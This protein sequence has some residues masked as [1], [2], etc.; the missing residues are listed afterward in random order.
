[1]ADGLF[2]IPTGIRAYQDDQIKLSELATRQKTADAS[3]RLADAQVANFAADNA[4]L[5]A[6]AKDKR[7]AEADARRIEQA[8]GRL[9]QGLPAD[10]SEAPTV[11]PLAGGTKFDALLDRGAAQV[12]YLQSIGR[13]KEANEQLAKLSGA[14]KNLAQARQAAT[15]AKENEWDAATRQHDFTS[16]ILSGVVDQASYDQAR[17]ALSASPLFSAEDLA[18]LPAKYD[19]RFVSGAIAGSAAAKQKADLAREASRTAMQN[20]NDADQIKARRLAQELANKTH[21]LA[22][23][24]EER[25]RAKGANGLGSADKPLAPPSGREV[26]M[27]RS[28]LKRLGLKVGDAQSDLINDIAEQVKTLVDSNPGLSR[29]EATSRIVGE[30]RERGEL[31]GT[32]L[33]GVP[34]GGNRYKPKEGSV[35]M[36]LPTPKT[37]AELKK[38][39]YYR[40]AED[41]LVK[42]FDGKG[43]KVATRR[44]LADV[45]EEE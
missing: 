23:E 16:R 42:L 18:E 38:G 15:A 40:D 32:T 2:G 12:Q 35:T 39:Y 31:E 44:K 11:S 24:R 17:M 14:A 10:G 3:A 22:V 28:E 33:L 37:A 13:A 27:A 45:T 25:L 21:Q 9:A 4:R 6:A 34:L 36:P 19:P 30:M 29:A 41:G 43:F 7:E 1:M 5:D 20:K 26:E 8:L